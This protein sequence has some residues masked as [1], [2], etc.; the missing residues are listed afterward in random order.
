LKRKELDEND[1]NALFVEARN[2]FRKSPKSGQVGEMLVYFLLEAVVRAPQALRKM[3]LTTN[4]GEERKGSDG[5]HIKWN[6]ELNILEVYFS[7]AKIWSNFAAAL[8]DA[9]K[10]IEEFHTNGM[11]QHELNLFSSHFK[12]LDTELQAK[13]LSYIEGENAPNTRVNHACLVGFDW[14]EYK[15]LDDLRRSAFIAEFEKRYAEWGQSA[16]SKTESHLLTFPH[17][18]LGFEFFFILFKD[19]QEFRDQFS[20]VL[21]G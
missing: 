16:L 4:P 9:F 1:R 17:K 8:K 13:I 7:E 10:S 2:L 18:N 6:S 3:S 15:S 5:V 19:V 14:D 20:A 12:I 11:K 21:W